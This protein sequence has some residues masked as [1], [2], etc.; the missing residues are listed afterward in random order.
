MLSVLIPSYN[1]EKNLPVALASAL[2]VKSVS[3]IIVVDDN[4]SDN[5]QKLIEDF[6]SERSR[7]KYFKNKKNIGSG[8]S[9]IKAFKKSNNSFVVMLNS[10][11]FFIPQAIDELFEYLM[12]NDLDVAYGR[13]AIKK[14][15]EIYKF[16]HLGYK[17]N[18]YI[19]NRDE[20]KDLLIFDMYMPSF[21]TII[22]KKSINSFYNEIYYKN[23]QK[24]YGGYFKAHDYDLFINLAKQ[25]KKFGFLNKTVCVWCP[26]ER[27][28]SGL[29]YFE[30]GEAS[31]ESAFLFNRYSENEKFDNLSLNLIRKRIDA[32]LKH[33]CKKDFFKNKFSHHYDIFLQNIN[34][35]K[36]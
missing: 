33:K 16:N 35:L 11:D 19:D 20:F 13:M 14:N 6:S 28:Q 7:I 27:S 1:D 23:L 12:K 32:K 21:G 36:T 5:T 34:E 25:K 30:S 26:K 29:S 22:K 4:S 24:S 31:Y 9:F 10:D 3:E 15:S 17:T 18:S 2:Q 8:M